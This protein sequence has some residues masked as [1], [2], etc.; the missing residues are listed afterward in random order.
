MQA[1]P[2]SA[3]AGA[4]LKDWLSLVSL[5]LIWGASF[6][7][8][9]IATTGLGPLSIAGGRIGL[10]ALVL[11]GLARVMGLSLPGWSGPDGARIWTSALGLGFFSM[12]LPFFLLGWGQARVPS[13]F[14]GVTMAMS[15]LLTL[16]LAH[17]FVVGEPMTGRKTIGMLIG[18][19]GVVVLIGGDVFA[20]SGADGES[21]ARL[22]CA[23]AA[24]SYAVGA[25]V[26]R[27]A[28]ASDPIGFATIA[29]LLAAAMIVPLALL[30][31]GLPRAPGVAPVLAIV[32][33]GL[34]PTALA[35]LLLVA[36][37]RSAG[38]SFV[39][40]VNYQVPVWSVLFGWAFLGELLPARVFAALALI[41][42]GVAISQFNRR[43]ALG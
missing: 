18:F 36:I 40:L 19:A 15:P 39:S 17:F 23:G 20:S 22:A 27:R 1:S 35:N 5:G 13:G 41:L 34:I 21:L 10:G 24:A 42:T 31:E 6:M 2:P 33:L 11:F 3:T 25:I 32:F 7:A 26:T 14:A 9:S 43:R 37:I 28:P 12:V 30:V 16:V 29:T 4:G 8:V 38:P